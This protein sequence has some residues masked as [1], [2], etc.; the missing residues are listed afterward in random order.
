MVA[1]DNYNNDDLTRIKDVV[2][3]SGA[4]SDTKLVRYLDRAFNKMVEEEGVYHG[5]SVPHAAPSDRIKDLE[6]GLAGGRYLQENRTP[7]D[8]DG[9][10]Y[11]HPVLKQ[12]LVEWESYLRT[13]YIDTERPAQTPVR[14][15]KSQ[16][17]M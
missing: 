15:V 8:D 9:R 17:K 6:A 12:Y 16:R 14:H 5:A 7:V 4:G 3:I 1:F 11:T 13:T 10:E 2:K